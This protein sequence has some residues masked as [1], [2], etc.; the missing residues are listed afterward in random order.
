MFPA[1]CLR[2]EVVIHQEPG[3]AVYGYA[4]EVS[5]PHTKELLCKAAEPTKKYSPVYPIASTV[6]TDLRALL[7]DVMDPDP[8]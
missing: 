5:D 8:F 3:E 6:T 1:Q 7:L 4:I 2:I